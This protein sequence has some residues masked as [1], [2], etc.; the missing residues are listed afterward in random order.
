MAEL[1]VI[2]D[3]DPAQ[4][5]KAIADLFGN[6]K[7]PGKFERIKTGFQTIAPVNE[8]IETPDKANAVFL[9]SQRVNMDENDPDYAAMVFGNYMLGGGFLN[10]RLATRIRQKEGLSYG[11]GSSFMAKPEERDGQFEVFAIAA[12]QNVTKVEAAL[13]DELQKALKDGFTQKEMDADRDGWLQSQ[14][15]DRSD[16]RSLLN[17]IATRDYNDRTLAWDEQLEKKVAALTPDDVVAAMRRHLDPAQ[18][19]IVK[20]G[21]FQKAAVAK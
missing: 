7:S 17:I 4:V 2:G 8:T 1:V 9:A 3:F 15:V 13:K 12:P 6:W 5:K 14:Q 21:D 10:S 16:D 19:I 11:I 20:A 18:M